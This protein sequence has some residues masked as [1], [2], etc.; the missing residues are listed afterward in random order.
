MTN[1]LN[2][3]DTA[4]IADKGEG[5]KLVAPSAARNCDAICDLLAE[6]APKEGRALEIASGTGQHVVAFA[7]LFP[8]LY[9]Q[10]TDGDAANL[11]SIRAWTQGLPN[12]AAPRVLDACA[13]GWGKWQGG[14][15]SIHLT[16]LLHL[17]SEPEAAILL[18]EVAKALAPGGIFCLYGPFRRDGALVTDGDR[19]FDASLRAQ[20]PAIGYKDIA[21]VEAQ[22]TGAGLLRARLVEM[23]AGNLM[24]VTQRPLQG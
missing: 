7:R 11:A 3:P 23:P 12:I 21:W 20:D 22:L 19:A 24:L 1:R 10:P 16:N 13:P 14:W 2:L 18:S 9:W 4:S 15:N 8:G 17:I 6:V 5:D